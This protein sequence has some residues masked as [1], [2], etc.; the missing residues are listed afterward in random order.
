MGMIDDEFVLYS[1][2]K[3]HAVRRLLMLAENQDYE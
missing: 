2:N 3:E 1:D